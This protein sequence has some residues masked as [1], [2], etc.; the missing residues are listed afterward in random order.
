MMLDCH[1]KQSSRRNHG[2]SRPSHNGRALISSPLVIAT[3][4]MLGKHSN[5]DLNVTARH[6]RSFIHPLFHDG[7]CQ[8]S[9]YIKHAWTGSFAQQRKASHFSVS[10]C[11]TLFF[12]RGSECVSEEIHL[13]LQLSDMSMPTCGIPCDELL[14]RSMLSDQSHG[15]NVIQNEISLMTREAPEA[16]DGHR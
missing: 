9:A 14:I 6:I 15:R 10:I 13:L 8:I 4:Q 1:I 7:C 5:A 2:L 16:V 3:R 12:A 11:F